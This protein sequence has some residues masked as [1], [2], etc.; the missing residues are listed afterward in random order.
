VRK[1][2]LFL[3]K[4]FAFSVGFFFL[5][6]VI[7]EYALSALARIVLV[8]LTLFG[9]K[10]T[11]VEVVGKTI[12]FISAIPGRTCKCDVE[13]APIG[14]IVFLSLAFSTSPLTRC[15]RLKA[16]GLGLLLLLCF[17]SLYLSLRVL[18]FAP[19]GVLGVNAYLVRFFVPA[20]I[21]FPVVL[22]VVLFPIN[23]LRFPKTSASVL[24]ADT[25]PVCGARKE[26]MFAHI[27]EAHGKGKKGLKSQAAKRYF[28]LFRNEGP[29]ERR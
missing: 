28:E 8:P 24:K 3:L 15:R 10:P 25:C 7:E 16:A 27:R 1:L 4:F 26:D 23:L 21:L 2:F 14:F 11:G 19:G 13:L 6:I 18:L 5:W 17:H 9:Y 12:R 22:W 20:G 29:G